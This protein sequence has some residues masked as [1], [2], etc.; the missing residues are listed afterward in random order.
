MTSDPP[1]PSAATSRRNLIL[2]G[3]STALVIIAAVALALTL[4]AGSPG[5]SSPTTPSATTPASDAPTPVPSES[6]TPV[7]Q[8]PAGDP[9]PIDTPAE[10]V[11]GLT[12]S[13]SGIEAVDG[14]AKGPGEVSGPS[15]RFTVTI[16]NATGAPVDL[17]GTVVTVDYG[18]DRT[19]RGSST[20]RAPSPW[21]PLWRRGHSIR[22]LRV[23]DS[24]RVA[25]PRA[26]HRRLRGR[27]GA[28]RVRGRHS[29]TGA[30]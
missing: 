26:H 3:A 28:A 8:P 20:S 7:T 11:T 22:G 12:A 13:I 23:R 27:C 25:G 18:A 6:P 14:V 17:T 9:V 10:V 30:R 2:A 29:V 21:P 16:A 1:R 4:P 5:A 19:P 15:I 24:A